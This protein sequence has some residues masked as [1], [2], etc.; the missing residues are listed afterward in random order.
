MFVARPG[1]RGPN[2]HTMRFIHQWSCVVLLAPLLLG[3]AGCK[4]GLAKKEDKAKPRDEAVPVEVAALQRGRI[5][6]I[7]K[8]STDL[9]AEHQ[10]KVFARAAN[11]VMKLLVEEGDKVQEGQLLVKLEDQMQQ[12]ALAK[13]QS[14][15][16]KA[17]DEFKRQEALHKQNLISDQVFTDAKHELR[18]LQLTVD[19]A[20]RQLDYTE[21]RAPIQGTVTLRLVNLGDYVTQNQH[22]FDI[23]DFDSIVA[24]VHLPE[25]YLSTLKPDQEARITTTALREKTFEGYVKRISPIVDPRS[26]T[27]KV[28]LGVRNLDLL[29]PGMYVDVELVL[30]TETNALLISKRSLVYDADQ[31]YVYR[32]LPDRK[33]ERLLV[34]PRL[35]DRDNLEPMGGFKEGDQIV[36]AGQTGLKDGAKVRL[37]GDPEPKEEEPGKEKAP[38][39][40]EQQTAQR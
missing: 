12:I 6:S 13:A 19:D 2:N 32:L 4:Q 26:G 27:I 28:T 30:A 34:E 23:I 8:A 16:A 14:Q 40:R 1:K 5:E 21:V 33:V 22:L 15:L 24:R 39:S 35:M 11:I 3:A 17:Q 9:E 20:Q 25:K 18:Q 10:V 36:I 29:R 37:P 31:L 7:I 38:T